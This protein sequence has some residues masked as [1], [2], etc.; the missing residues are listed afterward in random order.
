VGAH[1]YAAAS[2]WLTGEI[3]KFADFEKLPRCIVASR[4]AIMALAKTQDVGAA[5]V[6]GSHLRLY[7]D[8]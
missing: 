2:V 5:N 4:A 3:G 1:C 8:A 6:L 7:E